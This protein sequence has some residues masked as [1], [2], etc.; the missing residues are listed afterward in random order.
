MVK[1]HFGGCYRGKRAKNRLKWKK[2]HLS[3]TIS[4]EQHNIWSWF[5]VHL[6][7]LMISWGIFFIFLNF[8]FFGLSEWGDKRAKNSIYNS[9]IHHMPY[10]RNIRGHDHDFC[11][12]CVKWWYLQG[13]FS[14][15]LEFLYFGLLWGEK[16]KV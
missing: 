2:L 12:T 13:Y 1:F 16:G 4:Q 3:H 9:Y 5:L 6:C 14:F 11:C 10:L 7:K 15:F 8:S